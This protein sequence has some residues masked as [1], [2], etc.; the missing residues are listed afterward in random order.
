MLNNIFI[1]TSSAAV[2]LQGDAAE[3]LVEILGSR[4]LPRF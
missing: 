1:Y 4:R 2:H 3:C